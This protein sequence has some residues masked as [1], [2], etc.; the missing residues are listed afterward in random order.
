MDG[1]QLMQDL[2]LWDPKKR[3]SASQALRYPYFN[4]GQNLPKP[5]AQVPPMRKVSQRITGPHYPLEVVKNTDM[6]N[7]STVDQQSQREPCGH[8]RGDSFY[9]NHIELDDVSDFSFE[10]PKPNHQ[11]HKI[12][13]TKEVAPAG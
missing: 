6:M 11:Q 13:A 9:K 10:T 7:R 12:I 4:V 1:I 8:K 2:L 3:P 5:T